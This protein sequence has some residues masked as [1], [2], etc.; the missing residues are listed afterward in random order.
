MNRQLEVAN[1]RWGSR[2][3]RQTYG[4]EFRTRTV[5]LVIGYVAGGIIATPEFYSNSTNR[6]RP[7]DP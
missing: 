5:S 4:R 1:D 2:P 7:R 3:S 6:H